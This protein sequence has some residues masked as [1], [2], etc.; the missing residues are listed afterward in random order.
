M[1]AIKA[2]PC[3]PSSTFW[4]E[5]TGEQSLA[6]HH[7]C[8]HERNGDQVEVIP[9]EPCADRRGRMGPIL[10]GHLEASGKRSLVLELQGES[11]RVVIPVIESEEIGPQALKPSQRE[12][13]DN[14]MVSVHPTLF[15][16]AGELTRNRPVSGFDEV[17]PAPMRTGWIYVF[18]RGRLWR[19]VSVLTLEDGAPVM[20]DT[21]LASVRESDS[22]RANDRVPVGPEI[23]V[24]H[25]PARLLGVDVWDEVQLAF[26]ETQW[27]WHYVRAMEE[28]QSLRNQRCRDARAVRAFL[29]RHSG[30]PGT[31]WCRLDA[32]P[33]M[34]SREHT[35]E[36]EHTC[37][38]H[39]LRDVN[40][41]ETGSAQQALV[42]QREAIES[43]GASVDADYFIE[44]PS[45]FPSWRHAHLRG[46][47]L[48]DIPE[49]TDAFES[50]RDRHLLTLH[51]RDPLQAARHLVG[52]VNASLALL[53]ALVDNV[54]KRPFGV[55]AELF[56]NNFRRS[57][58]PDGRDNPLYIDGGWF[59][60]RLD[61]SEEGRLCR[62]MYDV[63]R[64]AIREFV[65]GA[66]AAIVRMLENTQPE[67]LTAVLRDLFALESGNA[68]AGFYQTVPILQVLSLPAGRI[69]P[70]L[71]PQEVDEEA[72][73][74]AEMLALRIARGEHP[75]GAMLLPFDNNRQDCQ[76]GDATA[77]TLRAMVAALEDRSQSLRVM[78]GNVV[79]ELADHQSE[80]RASDTAAVLAATRSASSAFSGI[81]GGVAQW[82]LST[83][84]K[85]LQQKGATFTA[86]VSRIQGAFEG[87]AQAAIPGR[88]RVQL[89]GSEEGRAF[90]VLEVVDESGQTLTSGAAVGASLRLA[91]AD[92]FDGTV[93]DQRVR[94]W[95]HQST[96]SPMGLPGILV[97]FDL[98]NFGVAFE[99]LDAPNSR[100][101]MGFLSAASD[102]GVSAA[103]LIAL[104]PNQSKRL[105][106]E[107]SKWKDDARWF[108]ALT[109]KVN[110]ADELAEEVVR[111]KVE[112][113]GWVAGM[114]SA[115]LMTGDAVASFVNRRWRVGTTHLIQAGGTATLASS[116]IIAA[117]I[118]TP[119]GRRA[120]ER[121]SVQ[122][123]QTVLGRLIPAT[124]R[125]GG[126]VASGYVTALGFAIYVLGEALY[127]RV[128][129]DAVSQWLRTG[130]FSDDREALNDTLQDEGL[131][132]I[133]LVKAMTPVALRR[134]ENERLSGWLKAQRLNAWEEHAQS[135]LVFASPALAITGEPAAVELEI[136]YKQELFRI[137][138]P[139]PAGGW[140]TETLA[141]RSGRIARG[142]EERYDPDRQSIDFLIAKTQLSDL[143]PVGRY[144]RVKTRYSVKRLSLTFT[145][146]VWHREKQ[147]YTTRRVT[148]TMEDLDVEWR[149]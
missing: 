67:S 7:Y 97:V 40:G 113:F 137:L 37:P 79:R 21:D 136:A 143:I 94:H 2:P 23:D 128:K 18:F 12:Y 35:I 117:R 34:R 83:I 50:L 134:I 10:A 46:A 3:T 72:G 130:P 118:L 144:E 87:F 133:E 61:D 56:H 22:D 53:L 1:S 62:T 45:L 93:K 51:L 111:N 86:E 142:I 92:V 127:Y 85:E 75:V 115:A 19:E 147:K 112:A 9:M 108:T 110:V 47:R 44:T 41:Q 126:T 109:N 119:A 33:P 129:D 59:D 17:I 121:S 123:V 106:L 64:R 29:G 52:Q 26:S 124:A 125:W 138:G 76:I 96:T 102:L 101:V 77:E 36:R 14:L 73:Q 43:D 116:D 74:S 98:W 5:L 105:A 95:L 28:D 89:E 148:H 58:L 6:G 84:Q 141:T 107:V 57:V 39:W 135:V 140:Q 145:V 63:E 99:A 100:N 91:E 54:K 48:P 122:A 11:K 80:T 82:W 114:F 55:T 103:Q 131:A 81:A 66:Q 71:L 30:H 149:E 68:V 132:Y 78:E 120:V 42:A 24:I 38:G 69:D 65:K 146:D 49:G 25:V 70:L 8:L 60:N 90:V 139:N 20:R 16:D 32:M 88:T 4:L 15:C 104:L 31:D 27:A 13:Q